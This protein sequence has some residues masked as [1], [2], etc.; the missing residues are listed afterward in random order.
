ME[1][2]QNLNKLKETG[3]K[4]M[5]LKRN[6]AILIILI[7]A[8]PV[9]AVYN[10]IGIPDSSDIRGGLIEKWFEAPLE[11]VREN[12]PE[13]YSNNAGE[14]F[15]VRLEETETTF[16]IFVAPRDIIN[17]NVY[18]SKG[19]KR[20]QQEV[21]PGDK[22]G[23]WVLIKDKKSEKPLRIRYYFVENSDV[24]IQ[25]SPYGKIALA[26]LVIFGNYAAKGASTGV[27]FKSFYT[28]SIED[29]RNM[30]NKSIPWDYVDIDNKQYASLLQ[31]A[32]VIQKNL[33]YIL[34]SHDGVY[35]ENM[36][37]VQVM[38]GK[39]LPVEGS[40]SGKLC[41]SS[42]GFLKWIADGLVEPLTGGYLKRE[43]LITPTVEYNSTGRIGV[44]SQKYDLFFALNWIRNL[45][46]AVVSINTGR[47]YTY[48]DSGVDVTINPFAASILPDGTMNTS[49]Y[50]PNTGY[51]ISV[52][53]GLLYVLAATEPDT[54][55]FAAI[56]GTDRTVVPEI[57]AFNECVVFM[58]YFNSN[59]LFSCF[60][61]MNGR[62][63]TLDD[64]CQMYKDDFVYLTRVRASDYFF[65]YSLEN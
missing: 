6:L 35:D 54:I 56:K 42:A 32:G 10:S 22:A 46:S 23:S 64:F 38:N 3:G 28:T 41:L 26:D 44:L 24:Y 63:V 60:V 2:L 11:Q 47:T 55:Y 27:P 37:L 51:E 21:Y 58:P 50:L 5:K 4:I 1:I 9:F 48:K 49:S 36:E 39:P 7:T 61:F 43:V 57:Q 52:L 45:S 33:P 20:E 17:V 25:F 34:H 59:D 29:I 53:K 62:A 14:K 8:L 18:S 65:P 40:D 31:M 12:L 15:Q 30:T 16:N 13:I 19:V